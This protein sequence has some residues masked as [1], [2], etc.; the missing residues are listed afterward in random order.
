[1]ILILG[2]P[3]YRHIT[4]VAGHLK[5]WG[6][7]YTNLDLASGAPYS[8]EVDSSGAVSVTSGDRDLATAKVAWQS[9]KVIFRR[10]GDDEEWVD[11]YMQGI[12][13]LDAYRNI[14]FTLPCIVVNSSSSISAC[15]NKLYQ[16][17]VA[18]NVGIRTP[19]YIITNS[20][21][22]ITSWAANDQIVI[23]ALGLP[24]IPAMVDGKVK[25]DSISTT[26]VDREYLTA[27]PGKHETFPLHIQKFIRKKFEYRC[28]VVEQSIF[29][30]RINPAQHSIME[31]DYRL[32]GHMVDYVPCSLPNEIET[33]LLKLMKAFALFSGCFDL[34]E[35]IDGEFYFLE[36]NP[37]GVWG[38]HDE[39]YEKQISKAFASALVRLSST[40]STV[41]QGGAK[42]RSN[43]SPA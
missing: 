8:V 28:V 29:P 43:G 10:F 26:L 1:M 35:D 9:D 13:E 7:E 12:S 14:G 6:H 34:I 19:G 18:Q 22:Q 20:I 41:N 23:K 39:I 17:F 30:L 32:G 27:N 37:E 36:V 33:V 2:S 3:N 5:S 24:S 15:R 16:L 25:Q 4:N 21:D 42:Y 11:E 31:V 40:H 38:K